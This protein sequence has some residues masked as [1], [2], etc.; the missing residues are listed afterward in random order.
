MTEQEFRHWA[1][2]H[3][4]AIERSANGAPV[5][6]LVLSGGGGA[7]A[8]GAG[9][10]SGWSRLGTRPR[11]QIVTGV[12]VGALIAPFAFLG[13][14]WDSQLTAAF[15][16]EH[17][18]SLLERRVF[19]WLAALF[20]WSVF[21]GDPLRALVDRNVTPALLHAVAAQ[22]ARGRLLLVATT[23]LDSGEVMVWNMGAIAAQGGRP[24]LKLFRQVLTASASIPGVFPPVLIPVRASHSVFDEMHVDGSASSAFLFAPGIVSILPQVIKPLHGGTVYLVI[25]GH[26]RVRRK[27]TRNRTAAIL[28]RSVD[29]ELASDS[30]ARIKLVYSFALRQR[31]K[32]DV[33]E[34]PSSYPLGGFTTALDPAKMKALFA[35]GE[36]CAADR[37]VWGSALTVL[38]RVASQRADS[39]VGAPQCPARSVAGE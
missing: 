6:V 7:G 35:Y 37:Q 23:D 13:P 9:V 36:R 5:N 3:L 2:S 12:S 20:G 22:D 18:P 38:N 31:M 17:G 27:T 14:R 39:P 34:I 16:G 19:G 11:F 28:L 8:F 24:A 10:L 29:T 15:Q 32:L 25:N 30:R 1:A 4:T 21:R 26:L 33:T